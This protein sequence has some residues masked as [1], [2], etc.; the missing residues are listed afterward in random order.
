M[1][2]YNICLSD[3]F[4]SHQKSAVPAVVP[5]TIEKTEQTNKRMQFFVTRKTEEL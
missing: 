4:T 3:H 1:I 5:D 2:I